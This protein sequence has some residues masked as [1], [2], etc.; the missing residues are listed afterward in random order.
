MEIRKYGET[1]E[2]LLLTVNEACALTGISKSMMYELVH[3]KEIEVIYVGRAIR[4]PVSALN[5][6]IET[7]KGTDVK[8]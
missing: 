7:K 6:W 5:S 1:M 3:R 2:K 4:I 8:G